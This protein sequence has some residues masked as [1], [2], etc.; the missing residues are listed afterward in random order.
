MLDIVIDP[1]HG[2]ASPVGKSTPYG[3]HLPSGR[4]EKDLN[5]ELARA[6]QASLPGSRLTRGADHNLSLATRQA[7]ASGSDVFVSLHAAPYGAR[8]SV[9]VHPHASEAAHGLGACLARAVGADGVRA[10]APMAVLSPTGL[11]PGCAACLVETDV[12]RR[13]D[14]ATTGR[15][16]ASAIRDYAGAYDGDVYGNGYFTDTDQL[17]AY[18]RDQRAADTRRVSTVADAQA[19][20]DA[21]VRRGRPNVWPHLNANHVGDQ[22]KDRIQN[23]RLFQQGNLNLCGPAS[24]FNMWA[25]RDP[26]A[27]ARYALGMMER[28]EG[29]MGSRTVRA[30]SAHKAVRYPRMGSPIT[31]STPAADFLVMAPLRHNTNAILPYEGSSSGEA[32]GA[33]TTPGE[34][35]AWMTA[36]GTW[37]RV[38]DEAN[39]ARV[40]G[41]DHALG[42]MPGGGQDIALLVNVNALA[43]A[44][45][46]QNLSNAG[47]SNPFTPDNT[48][49]LNQFPN[50]FILLLAEV[51]PD[52]SARTLS[53]SVWTWGGSYEF[54][55]VP[56]Q[57]FMNN[58]YGAVK[59]S[60]RR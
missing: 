27:Y 53:M 60:T 40:R 42:L 7:R 18:M 25:G 22:I 59:G 12:D 52:T 1:G 31:M 49:I 17:T 43:S 30:T 34:L 11:A 44:R 26:V 51:V 57:R 38:Q 29:R 39:W 46:V 3:C 9:W 37:S 32:I 16:I 24:F 48:F 58:Y 14:L 8:P 5:L 21:W 20:V 35:A 2:G 15:V 54:E 47:R 36:T 13:G 4:E 45:R 28:G 50:H 33:A 56:M 10:D 23:S 41:Y 6:V 55:G 19:L